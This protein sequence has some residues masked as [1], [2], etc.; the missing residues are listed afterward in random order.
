MKDKTII[1]NNRNEMNWVL[2]SLL[3]VMFAS[4]NLNAQYDDLYYDS[5]YDGYTGGNEHLVYD[6]DTIIDTEGDTYVTNNYYDNNDDDYYYSRRL[7]RFHNRHCGFGYYSN[8]Y[9]WNY[10][11]GFHAGWNSPY[12]S[13]YYYNPFNSYG[14]GYHTVTFMGPSYGWSSPNYYS[15]YNNS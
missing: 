11:F 12:Y 10:P 7:R 2:V 4:F 5:S 15:Y 3:F 1:K 9:N 13:S 14:W 6:S 8:Y